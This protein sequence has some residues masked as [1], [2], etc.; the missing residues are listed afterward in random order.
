MREMKNELMA[1]WDG[2]RSGAAAAASPK[3]MVRPP[4]WCCAT[5]NGC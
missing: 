5:F 4:L 1:Q 2:L 3:I